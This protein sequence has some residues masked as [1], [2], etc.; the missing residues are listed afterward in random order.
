MEDDEVMETSQQLSQLSV[1]DK[2]GSVI[3]LSDGSE[4]TDDGPPP[5]KRRKTTAGDHSDSTRA[6]KFVCD[7]GLHDLC[8]QLRQCGFDSISI[9]C[10][11]AGRTAL[12]VALREKRVWLTRY[13][14]AKKVIQLMINDLFD[15]LYK[16]C[17]LSIYY[18]KTIYHFV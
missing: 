18:S 1:S 9:Q 13:P 17:H 2:D 6:L 7:W 16:N 12:D 14:G 11:D 10:K 3:Y 8:K 5:E 4:E 15:R